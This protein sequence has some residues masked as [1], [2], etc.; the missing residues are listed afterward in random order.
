MAGHLVIHGGGATAPEAS[1]TFI[2][3][4]GG[5]DA[6]LLVLA[7]TAEDAPAKAAQSIAFLRQNGARNVI[8]PDGVDNVLKALETARGV[9]I[10]GGDQNRLMERIGTPAVL[11]AV[12]NVVMKRG[13]AAGG[14]SAGASLMGEWMPT[15]DGDRTVMTE[16]AVVIAPGLG[17]LPRILVDSHFLK[18]ERLQ[19]LVNMV[20]SQ[21]DRILIGVGV[22]EN[23]W[24]ETDDE[25][26]T[27]TVRGDK[28]AVI[29]Q[30]AT[31]SGSRKGRAGALGAR[32]VR[33]SFLLPGDTVSL[34]GLKRGFPL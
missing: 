10:P 30:P 12:R 4:A 27:L 5:P 11:A 31:T 3:R 29:V 8:A 6:P 20:L 21:P 23:G 19:R 1:R 16:G 22:N 24:I 25:R 15:G 34:D 7:Q 33:V 17:L 9:W 28:Q 26:D 2:A 32:N 18:R 13:G 14:S